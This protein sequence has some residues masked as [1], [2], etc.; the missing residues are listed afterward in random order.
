MGY[1]VSQFLDDNVVLC[2]PVTVTT[3]T[4]RNGTNTQPFCQ[5]FF[6]NTFQL[7]VISRDSVYGNPPTRF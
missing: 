5:T 7:N 2:C 1:L 6:I 4:E 3:Q